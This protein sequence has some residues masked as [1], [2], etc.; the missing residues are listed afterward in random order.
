MDSLEL[1]INNVTYE[2]ISKV[3]LFFTYVDIK[4]MDGGIP[5]VWKSKNKWTIYI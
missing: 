3:M 1:W 4:L 5:H 2:L